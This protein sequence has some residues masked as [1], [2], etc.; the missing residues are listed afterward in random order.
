MRILRK[1]LGLA[2]SK[3]E[4]LDDRLRQHFCAVEAGTV[5]GAVSL[6]PIDDETLQLKQM[7][8]LETKRGCRVGARLLAHAENWA[9]R[10]G[11]RLVIAHARVGAEGF[12][13]GLGY[14]QEGDPFEE[15]T[16]P[17]VRV[18]KQIGQEK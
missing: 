12:Y 13:L 11:C 4:L 14:V 6:R 18:T 16:I 10:N 8:V 1:P 7:A 3:D 15:H 2:F 9:A 17:H 5:I